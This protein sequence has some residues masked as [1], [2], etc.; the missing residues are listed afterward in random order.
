MN[1]KMMYVQEFKLKYKETGEIVSHSLKGVKM[2]LHKKIA[3]LP[4]FTSRYDS[5]RIIG[6]QIEDRITN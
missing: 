3:L 6:T 2:I 1:A 4:R 5:G